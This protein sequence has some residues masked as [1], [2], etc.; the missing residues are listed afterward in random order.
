[1][2]LLRA[3]ILVSSV[4][5]YQNVCPDKRWYSTPYDDS[6]L[7]ED[8]PKEVEHFPEVQTRAGWILYAVKPGAYLKTS[9]RCWQIATCKLHVI[10]ISPSS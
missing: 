5:S 9:K 6:P 10:D 7:L 2:A 3:L 8:G 4:W 1:M